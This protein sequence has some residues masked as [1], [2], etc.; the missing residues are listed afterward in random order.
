MTKQKTNNVILNKTDTLK[1]Q[2]Q[3]QKYVTEE[4]ETIII[5]KHNLYHL[6]TRAVIKIVVK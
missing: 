3:Q 5:F 1:Q 2:Q 6:K 4:R